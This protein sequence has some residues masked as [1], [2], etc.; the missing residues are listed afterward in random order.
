[1]YP[2]DRHGIRW[3]AMG[4]AGLPWDPLDRHGIFWIPWIRWIATVS[5]I[6]GIRFFPLA[7]HDGKD[8]NFEG[9]I[10]LKYIKF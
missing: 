8:P 7:T 4:S 10:V 2:L 3:I 5:A 6:D 9:H 1:M